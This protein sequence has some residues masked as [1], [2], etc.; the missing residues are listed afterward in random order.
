MEKRKY[1]HCQRCKYN[2]FNYELYMANIRG[3]REGWID[4]IKSIINFINEN[5]DQDIND[6]IES[7]KESEKLI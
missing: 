1:N 6:I 3:Y 4:S 7:L 5:A 2:N